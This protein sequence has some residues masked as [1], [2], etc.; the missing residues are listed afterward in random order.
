VQAAQFSAN[1]NHPLIDDRFFNQV[2]VDNQGN[3]VFHTGYGFIEYVM[4]THSSAPDTKIKTTANA[5]DSFTFDFSS[6]DASATGSSPATSSRAPSQQWFKWRLDDEPWSQPQR[7]S[8][9]R[10]DALPGGKHR[11]EAA[12]IDRHLLI[13]PTPALAAFSVN[14]DPAKQVA[15]FIAALSSPDYARREAA[16]AGLAKQ[17]K[18]ALP[19]L[20]AA[21]ATASAST[22]WWIDAAIQQ[23]E[24]ESDRSKTK[25]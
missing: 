2:F 13:D 19:A 5:V 11:I 1:E 15:A 14:I 4:I 23:I 20:K 9:V 24:S 3:T 12:A 6:I 7:T 10:L 25:Q 17:P 8:H 18:R 21:R 16:V 22:Q